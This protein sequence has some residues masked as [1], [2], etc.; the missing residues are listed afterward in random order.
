MLNL[1]VAMAMKTLQALVLLIFI[2]A[3]H[4]M[5]VSTSAPRIDVPLAGDEVRGVVGIAGSTELEGFDS[6]E[7]F[8]GF[9]PDGAWF[10]L[11]KQNQPVNNQIIVNWDTTIIPDGNY[12]IRLVVQ[13]K[14][15]SQVVTGVDNI[16]VRNYSSAGQTNPEVNASIVTPAGNY[17]STL[18]RTATPLPRNPAAVSRADLFASLRAGLLG[19]A[20][21][22]L[23][24][25][26][27]LGL[28]W[29][30]KRR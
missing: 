23:F 21:L 5:Q 30:N 2:P 4:F 24:L 19:T 20:G 3:M 27:Y 29:L 9:S 10:S 1:P 14:D 7:V 12:R 17:G 18:E 16:Q 15:G 22:F 6:S 8:F 25:G 28:R 11:G 26:L 13:R